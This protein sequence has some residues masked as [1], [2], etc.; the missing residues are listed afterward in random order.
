MT[1]AHSL[2]ED[3]SPGTGKVLLHFTMSLD[4]FIAGPNHEM[5]WT[6]GFSELPPGELESYAERT[7]AVLCGRDGIDTTPDVSG[8]YGDLWDGP[9]FILTHHPEDAPS[10]EGAQF[11]SCDVAEAVQ[12]GLDAA[13]GKNLEIFSASIGQQ[14]VERGLIDQIELHII[15]ILIGRGRRLFGDHGGAPIRFELLDVPDPLAAVTVRCQ[16]AAAVPRV[17]T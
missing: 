11:L 12:I 3:T 10:V 15:P 13:K 5:D 1:T 2:S 17:S 9:V 4:G 16:P 14:L 6:E 8:I 7:G